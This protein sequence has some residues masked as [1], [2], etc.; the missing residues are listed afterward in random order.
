MKTLGVICARG[1]SK[2]LPGKNLLDLGGK[3]VVAWSVEAATAAKC[4]DRTI[5]STDDVK[6][7]DVA[8]NVGCDVPFVRPAHLATDTA[9]I[10]DV[11]FHAL[12]VLED[13]FDHIVLLQA[14]SPLRRACDID[15]CIELMRHANAP[16]AIS[17]TKVTKP[18]QWMYSLETDGGL[19]PAIDELAEVARRQEAPDYVVPNGA[20]YAAKVAWLRER[21]SFVGRETRAFLMPPERSVDI[22]NLIDLITARALLAEMQKGTLG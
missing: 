22:D 5:L 11:L 19:V 7:A 6:I 14:T 15:A 10:Y 18:P 8:R 20:V 21:R 4:L 16:A 9:S 17:V 1:G 3:P 13:D 12:D 2:G